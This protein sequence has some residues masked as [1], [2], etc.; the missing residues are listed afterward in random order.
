[1]Q[2]IDDGVGVGLHLFRH[3]RD[4]FLFQ[5]VMIRLDVIDDVTDPIHRLYQLAGNIV[6]KYSLD[7]FCLMSTVT[8]NAAAP[9]VLLFLCA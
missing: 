2:E 5:S 7:A 9:Y 6:K 4:I 3:L 8:E 1:M